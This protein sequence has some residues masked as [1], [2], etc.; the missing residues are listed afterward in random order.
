MEATKQFRLKFAI[1]GSDSVTMSNTGL[2]AALIELNDSENIE[3]RGLIL[4]CDNNNMI[5]AAGRGPWFMYN[6]TCQGGNGGIVSGIVCYDSTFTSQNYAFR[7]NT[8]HYER[9]TFTSC[10]NGASFAMTMI[11][12]NFYAC[13]FSGCGACINMYQGQFENTTDEYQIY[14]T[15]STFYNCTK[16]IDFT[17]GAGLNGFRLHVQNS[18]FHTCTTVWYGN[19]ADAN[20]DAQCCDYNTYYNCT[21]VARLDGANVSFSSWQALT[22]HNGTSP[23]ANSVTTDPGLTDAAGDDFSLTAASNCRHAGI[24]SYSYVEK[25]HNGTAF[26]KFHPDKGAWSSGSGPNVAYGG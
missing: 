14:I 21:Q 2:G 20:L 5:D 24:G 3:L 8:C 6:C 7:F 1:N 22:D 4:N 17:A 18:I 19:G 9:C 25:G 10:T 26:D 23:D 15:N 13:V 16:V 12:V 11:R